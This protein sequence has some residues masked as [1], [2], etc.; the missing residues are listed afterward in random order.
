MFLDTRRYLGLLVIDTYIPVPTLACVHKSRI[1][2]EKVIDE[3][4]DYVRQTP[5]HTNSPWIIVRCA[6]NMINTT[7]T[8]PQIMSLNGQTDKFILQYA[9]INFLTMSF[10]NTR[11]NKPKLRY[12]NLFHDREIK[13]TV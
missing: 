12:F 10:K 7:Q 2:L 13:Q 8:V 3:I 4:V 11:Q 9:I 1:V 5:H 6:I